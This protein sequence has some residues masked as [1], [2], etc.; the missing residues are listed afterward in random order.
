MTNSGAM[1]VV[2][3]SLRAACIVSL[4]SLGLLRSLCDILDWQETGP[5]TLE[6]ESGQQD[7]G[8]GEEDARGY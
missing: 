6:P 2:T 7:A 8:A 4:Q 1:H 5:L 3:Q